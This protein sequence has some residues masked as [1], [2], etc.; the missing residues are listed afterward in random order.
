MPKAL[1]HISLTLK[2]CHF[3]VIQ[4][5]VCRTRAGFQVYQFENTQNLPHSGIEIFQQNAY[6]LDN[7]EYLNGFQNFGLHLIC[8]IYGCNIV[9]IIQVKAKQV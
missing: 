8:V 7:C 1:D 9:Y 5:E 2:L 3:P 6:L 4:G